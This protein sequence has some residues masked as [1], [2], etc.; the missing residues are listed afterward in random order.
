MEKG[1]GLY[2]VKYYGFELH[3]FAYEPRFATPV[4]PLLNYQFF[5]MLE[6]FGSLVYM[7]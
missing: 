2:E 4:T 6:N 5:K 7:N 1:K 3:D